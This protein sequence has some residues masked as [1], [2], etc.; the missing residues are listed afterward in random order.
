M[1]IRKASKGDIGCASKRKKKHI[2][3]GWETQSPLEGIT[4][5]VFP[6]GHAPAY[7]PLKPKL[8]KAWL[9]AISPTYLP[10]ASLSTSRTSRKKKG[11]VQFRKQG[12]WIEH[13]SQFHEVTFRRRG[14]SAL[15]EGRGIIRIVE[16]KHSA[17]PTYAIPAVD[18]R[19]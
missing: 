12:G 7:L 19:E 10:P 6:S 15:Y 1:I 17:V 4:G 13:F 8:V 9:L 11:P 16:E 18:Y 2:R 5:A 14:A 3:R